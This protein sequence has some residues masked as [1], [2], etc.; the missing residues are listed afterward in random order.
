MGK[1]NQIDQEHWSEYLGEIARTKRGWLVAVEVVSRHEV[2]TKPEIGLPAMG[3][4]L[5]ALEYE[6]PTKG[7]KIIISVGQETVDYEHAIDGPTEL[8]ENLDAY[9]RLSSLEILDQM[10]VCTRINFFD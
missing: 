6:P 3:T 2:L 8:V 7:D 1:R 9:G 5:I 10:E 4:P